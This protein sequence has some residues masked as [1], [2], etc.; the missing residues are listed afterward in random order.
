MSERPPLEFEYVKIADLVPYADNPR[1]NEAAVGPLSKSMEA[2]GFVAP[3]I[4]RRSDMTIIAG[5]TRLQ[6]AKKKGMKEVPVIF[7]VFTDDEL[8]QYNVADNKLAELAEWDM[9]KLAAKCIEWNNQ[10]IDIEAMG[11]TGDEINDIIGMYDVEGIIAP[12][13]ADGDREPFQQITFTLHDD[14]AEEVKEALTKAK[15]S[16]KI[17]VLENENS[18]GNA[19]A[20]ICQEYNRG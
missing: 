2:F 19:I 11:F 8:E 9:D 7:V 15:K 18:N 3:I 5:H 10:D 4:A 17:E 20:F 16:G 12:E 1:K 14:Q 13:L 6:A